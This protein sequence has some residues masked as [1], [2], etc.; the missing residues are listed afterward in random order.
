MKITVT[1]PYYEK[2]Y[3]TDL[4]ITR[5]ENFLENNRAGNET[6]IYFKDKTTEKDVC[7]NPAFFASIEV[8]ENAE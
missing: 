2:E 3:I 5:W 4:T 1:N 6:F 7:I 8:E